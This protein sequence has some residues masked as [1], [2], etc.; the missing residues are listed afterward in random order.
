MRIT[1]RQFRRL[2]MAD[3]KN[4]SKIWTALFILVVI[5]AALT[6]QAGAITITSKDTV[7]ISTK[8]AKD[9]TTWEK[10]E[11]GSVGS[12]TLSK[13]TTAKLTLTSGKEKVEPV[14]QLNPGADLVV[15]ANYAGGDADIVQVGKDRIEG[16]YTY[17]KSSAYPWGIY[18]SIYDVSG[19]PILILSEFSKRSVWYAP[20][21]SENVE[22]IQ[23]ILGNGEMPDISLLQ[24]VVGA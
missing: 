16:Y 19:K 18:W 15:S 3:E 2:I 5:F 10:L 13:P 24:K 17:G 1:L 22:E 21:S 11:A 6:A 9:A 20:I 14:V 23:G 4:G 8:D 12:V 7:A